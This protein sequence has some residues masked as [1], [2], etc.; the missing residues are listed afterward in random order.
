MGV[1]GEICA[2]VIKSKKE[3][4]VEQLNNSSYMLMNQQIIDSGNLPSIIYLQIRIKKYLKKKHYKIL[5]G[6]K[7]EELRRNTTTSNK[8]V[9]S[10]EN[11]TTSQS[12]KNSPDHPRNSP[13]EDA[14]SHNIRDHT[15][16]QLLIQQDPFNNKNSSRKNLNNGTQEKNDS[17]SL[18]KYPTNPNDP[19]YQE[20]DN[21][22]KK[23]PKIEEDGFA[24]VGEW[25]N[26]KR[27]GFGV[28]SMKD[29]SKFIGE[30]SDNI[31]YGFGMLIHA[32]GEK[33]A[34][35]WDDFKLNGWGYFWA[36]NNSFSKGLWKKDKLNEYGIESW[37]K[38]KYEGEYV[39]G[40]KHG[41]GEIVF[42]EKGYYVGEFDES[43]ITG[44][45]TFV[46]KDNRKYEGE[47]KNSKMHG[48]GMIT[49]GKGKSWFEGEFVKDKREGFGIFYSPNKIYLGIWKN[50]KLEGDT[51]IIEGN[52]IKKQ[53]WENGKNVKNLPDTHEIFFEKYVA[54]VI[55]IHKARLGKT[56]P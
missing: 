1:C 5:K 32:N 13:Y 24:Y 2:S 35:Y 4:D 53:F 18:V 22:R 19:R 30:F 14:I 47:W 20:H 39:D 28:L 34:G 27:D 6:K 17:K 44:V 25:K 48:F 49:V 26:G 45:G 46:F 40:S 52:N 33:C 7:E 23:Y 50:S 38:G 21:K 9:G 54:E 36:P 37:V 3:V 29:V 42:E 56:P 41:I 43:T 51:I 31:V 10:V 15:N 55:A 12:K 16:D 11:N 8:R